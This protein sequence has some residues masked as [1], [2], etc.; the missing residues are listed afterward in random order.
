MLDAGYRTV[1]NGIAMTRPDN[2]GYNRPGA[3]VID[4]WR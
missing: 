2:E 4:D 1:M 3:F